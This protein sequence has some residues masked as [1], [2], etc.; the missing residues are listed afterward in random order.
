LGA[1]V[2]IA[3]EFSVMDDVSRETEDT[4]IAQAAETAVRGFPAGVGDP[5]PA[6][7]AMTRVLTVANQ[8]GG[9]GKTTTTVNIAAALAL[10][11]F[12]RAGRR[13]R[14]AG[15]RL[16]G[17]RVDHHSEYRRSTTC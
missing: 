12:E 4:P 6:A 14:P 5:L 11:G 2:P 17:P 15:Q 16:D 7:P 10:Q 13:P 1:D 3:E 9:V 8:K